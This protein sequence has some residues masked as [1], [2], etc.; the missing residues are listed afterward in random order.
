MLHNEYAHIAWNAYLQETFGIT[1]T[2]D[3]LRTGYH[4]KTVT[5]VAFSRNEK[6]PHLLQFSQG[7]IR[8]ISDPKA[9]PSPTGWHPR[10]VINQG[11]V[12]Q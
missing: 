8:D 3:Y 1:E 11:R 12:T 5:S 6:R 2:P 7:P 10:R 4:A 9:Q